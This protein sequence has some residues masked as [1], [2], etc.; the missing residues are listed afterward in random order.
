MEFLPDLFIFDLFIMFIHS[1]FFKACQDPKSRP[2]FLNDK[3]LEQALKII[4]RKFPIMENSK[5]YNIYFMNYIQNNLKQFMYICVY[6]TLQ[7]YKYIQILFLENIEVLSLTKQN[8]LFLGFGS[9]S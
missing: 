7:R 6:P 3:S 9:V 5:V 8:L 4:V 1:I 2:A